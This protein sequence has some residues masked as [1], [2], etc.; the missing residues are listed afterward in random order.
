M[1]NGLDIYYSKKERS[2]GKG[3]APVNTNKK[4]QSAKG[5]KPIT[6]GKGLKILQ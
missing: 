3:L 6:K 5:L 1:I 2:Y 4:P